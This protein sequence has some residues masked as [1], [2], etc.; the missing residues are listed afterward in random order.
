MA[1]MQKNK[2]KTD[3]FKSRTPVAEDINYA[4]K[5]LEKEAYVEEHNGIRR[6]PNSTFILT[7]QKF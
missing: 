3:I 6:I 4:D 7:S 2:T 5:I 1:K